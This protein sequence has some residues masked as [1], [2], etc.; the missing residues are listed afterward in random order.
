MIFTGHLLISKNLLFPRLYA[1]S[2][3]LVLVAGET[4]HMMIAKAH[5]ES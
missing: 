5:V 4:K 2:F 3:I 1:E